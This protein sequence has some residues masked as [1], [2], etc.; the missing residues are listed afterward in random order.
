MTQLPPTACRGFTLVEIMVV[1][2]IIAITAASVGLG[3]ERL[4]QDRLEKQASE[5]S[6][7]LQ[8]LSDNAVLDGA[9][10]GAWSGD[11]GQRLMAGYF[12]EGRWWLLAEGDHESLRL[13]QGIA[14]QMEDET[15]WRE[16]AKQTRKGAA[17][18]EPSRVIFQPFGTVTPGRFRVS[19]GEPPRAATIERDDDGIF[20]WQRV[21]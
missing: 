8:A 7:W 13:Q 10:Y 5:L 19:E 15:G 11:D 2:A 12:L 16:L 9:V 17:A 20:S 3:F 4:Q 18:S 6:S 21:P 14:V 1:L